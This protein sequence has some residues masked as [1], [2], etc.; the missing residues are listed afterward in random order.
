VE[1]ELAGLSSDNYK[2]GKEKIV[3]YIVGHAPS[4]G[5]ARSDALLAYNSFWSIMARQEIAK[6][7]PFWI[8]VYTPPDA[9]AGTYH[10]TIRISTKNAGS[11]SIGLRLH[12]WN[13]SLPERVHLK[14]H[15]MMKREELR[16]IYADLSD[17]AFEEVIF[18]Y[19]TN[20]AEHRVSGQANIA[21][22][23]RTGRG[24]RPLQSFR[25]FDE[26]MSLLTRLGINVC[27]LHLGH[28]GPRAYSKALSK[29]QRHLGEKKWLD[30]AYLH[31]EASPSNM[32]P[33][34]QAEL[35][36]TYSPGI[37]VVSEACGIRRMRE[38]AGLVDVWVS[39]APGQSPSR[40]A[41]AAR[42]LSAGNELWLDVACRVGRHGPL[43]IRRNRAEQRGFFWRMWGMGAKGLVLDS[44]LPTEGSMEPLLYNWEEGVM[45]SVRWET[46]RDGIED[47]EYLALLEERA[48]ELDGVKAT[49]GI[50]DS[51]RSAHV[52][53]R[54]L[55]AT[56]RA[57]I[58]PLD[59]IGTRERV[60]AALEA[61][62][63]GT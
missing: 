23:F 24:G 28:M 62:D 55:L 14:T 26:D 54:R 25:R 60:A 20:S 50:P 9:E 11:R 43:C 41:N 56:I 10:G 13:F 31:L 59:L 17:K 4:R 22:P 34:R 32:S 33:M 35:A 57:R 29:L 5:S 48:D 18:R 51:L 7:Q 42:R 49:S 52:R 45:N 6:A 30:V 2:I 19:R 63:T 16:G 8:T 40:L 47:Y 1:L 38:L 12:V 15:F 58:G 39:K 27:C 36:R 21:P 3:S 44:A 61:L 46:I 53:G 37:R